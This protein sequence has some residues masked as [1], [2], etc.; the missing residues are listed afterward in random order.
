L[1]NDSNGVRGTVE[2]AGAGQYPGLVFDYD[3]PRKRFL[4]G[5]RA[6]NLVTITSFYPDTLFAHEFDDDP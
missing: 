1:L 4:V 3:P 6:S 5:R 2:F